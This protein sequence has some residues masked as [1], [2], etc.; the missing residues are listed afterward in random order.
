MRHHSD[1]IYDRHTKTKKKGYQSS[2]FCY[3]W[4]QGIAASEVRLREPRLRRLLRLQLLFLLLRPG[5]PGPYGFC[6]A[7]RL[8]LYYPVGRSQVTP[9]KY[10]LDSHEAVVTHTFATGLAYLVEVG[11]FE[12]PCRQCFLGRFTLFKYLF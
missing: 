7:E 1:S 8:S 6:I 5:C 10:G 2:L 4:S 9:I 11:G 3:F 12:P